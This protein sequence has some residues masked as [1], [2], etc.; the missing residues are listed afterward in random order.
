LI[1]RLGGR[2]GGIGFD[3]EA[4]N[5]SLILGLPGLGGRGGGGAGLATVSGSSKS[6][7]SSAGGV[8]SGGRL[9]RDC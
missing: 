6:S 1:L 5:G 4:L 2:G 8:G 7:N 3:I 9:L